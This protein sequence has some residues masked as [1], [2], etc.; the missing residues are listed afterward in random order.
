MNS[1]LR[2][3]ILGELRLRGFSGDRSLEAPRGTMGI[4]AAHL[5]SIEVLDLLDQMCVR[6]EKVYWS[7]EAV[8]REAATNSYEDVV[9]VIDAIKTVVRR[10]LA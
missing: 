3:A 7:V 10:R 5:D 4:S 8:G 9:L 6:R 2:D 1:Q